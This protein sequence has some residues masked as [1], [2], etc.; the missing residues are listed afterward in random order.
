[1]PLANWHLRPS[2]SLA[3]GA[4]IIRISELSCTGF[5]RSPDRSKI[6]DYSENGAYLEEIGTIVFSSSISVGWSHN[7]KAFN[8]PLVVKQLGSRWIEE[9]H[10]GVTQSNLIIPSNHNTFNHNIEPSW[11]MI[12]SYDFETREGI[13]SVLSWTRRHHYIQFTSSDFIWVVNILNCSLFKC[14]TLM[15]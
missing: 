2:R 5:W 14:L 6:R 9:L 15:F 8:S 7:E 3:A 4:G 13:K 11:D 10:R 12:L 1:M